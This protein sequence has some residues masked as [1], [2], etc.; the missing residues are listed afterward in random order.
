M[1]LSNLPRS[2]GNRGNGNPVKR[3]IDAS[4]TVMAKEPGSSP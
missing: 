2:A 1:V 4:P 3:E